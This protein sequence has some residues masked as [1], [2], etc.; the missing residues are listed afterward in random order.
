MGVEDLQDLKKLSMLRSMINSKGIEDVMNTEFPTASPEDRISDVTSL[1]RKT[2]YYDMPVVDKGEYVGMLSYGTVLKKR[3]ATLDTKIQKLVGKPPTVTKGMSITDVAEIMISNNSRQ[4]A[5][6][7][8]GGKKIVGIVSRSALLQAASEIK[9]FR[10]IKVWELMTNPVESVRNTAMLEDAL[11]IMTGLDIMTIPVV[12]GAGRVVGILGMKEVT[13][14]FRRNDPKT[15]GDASGSKKERAS[16][17]VETI[18]ATA[19]RTVSWDDDIGVATKIMIDNDISTLPVL[20]GDE[21]VGVLTQYDVVELIS[22][23]RE[24]EV[25]YVQIGGLDDNDKAYYEAMHDTVEKEVE[26]IAKVY[27]PSSLTIHV[28]KYKKAGENNKYSITARLVTDNYSLNLKEVGWDL[29]RT[30]SD[31]M[32]RMTSEVVSMKETRDSYRRRKR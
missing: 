25:L 13:E 27:K 15:V 19:P 7:N 1:M 26:K 16:V 22:A 4:L 9:S 2:K 11:D 12:D 30:V 32:K 29:V 18:S 10:E 31:L 17:P 23:C 21:L 24:R 8:S 6:L 14:Y 3:S 5:V 20:E 28:A